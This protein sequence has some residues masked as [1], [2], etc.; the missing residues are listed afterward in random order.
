M[1]LPIIDGLAKKT[2]QLEQVTGMKLGDNANADKS[3]SGSIKSLTEETGSTIAGQFNAVRQ[4]TADL[5]TLQQQELLIQQRQLDEQM[6]LS[7]LMREAGQQDVALLQ[8]QQSEGQTGALDAGKI[9]QQDMYLLQQKQYTEQITLS[10]LSLQSVDLQQQQV[11]VLRD[12][13][14]YRRETARNT[15]MLYQ[16]D[17]RLAD[18]ANKKSIPV[19]DPYRAKGL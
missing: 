3:L 8:R 7:A 6:S 1:T 19:T 14:I 4:Y 17:G 15:E 16:I 10:D 2:E 11:T 13:L 9:I 12:S 18:I 5:V